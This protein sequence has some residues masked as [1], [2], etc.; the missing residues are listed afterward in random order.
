MGGYPCCCPQECCCPHCDPCHS[1]AP[2]TFSI[3]G[4]VPREL[5]AVDCCTD[6]DAFNAMYSLDYMG[7]Q[8]AC[9]PSNYTPCGY[10]QSE[11]FSVNCDDDGTSPHNAIALLVVY[12]EPED[13]R[14]VYTLVIGPA[15]ILSEQPCNASLLCRPDC[16]DDFEMMYVVYQKIITGPT[17]CT[18]L[19][20]DQVC[21]GSYCTSWPLTV[22]ISQ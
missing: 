18:S 3:A 19:V 7:L 1:T 12:Y 9:N 11:P 16:V 21:F 15:R 2:W 13:D 22:T 17:N 4:P 20:M 6:C 8:G 14:C 10:W 5:P